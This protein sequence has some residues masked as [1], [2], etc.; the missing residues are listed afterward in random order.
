MREP[1]QVSAQ[2]PDAEQ[3]RWFAEEVQ[4][5][6]ASLRAYLR[7]QFPALFD[8]DDVV[9]E[10]FIQIELA[11]RSDKIVSVRG[12]LFTVAR[13]IAVSL[14]RK[15]KFIARTAVNELPSSCVLDENA[16]V[17]A[18]VCRRDE[19]D[20]IAEAI[21]TLPARCRE[22]VALRL[23]CGTENRV[24]A[25]KLGLSEQTV[26]VQVARGLKKCVKFLSK[27]GVVPAERT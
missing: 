3:I 13:N 5:H 17:V 22:I 1:V 24:I 4:P 20:L 6:E 8:V 7:R 25:Q 14:H 23:I 16:D 21:G 26:R 15:R 12:F 19:F 9:Q 27:R 11:Q 10:S 18:A 2:P